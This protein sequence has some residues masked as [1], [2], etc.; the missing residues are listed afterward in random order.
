MASHHGVHF[1][2]GRRDYDT[3]LGAYSAALDEI[4]QLRKAMAYEAA[5][6]EAHLSLKSFPKS[7]RQYAEKQ[8]E[9]MR[10]AA[11]GEVETAYAGC[12][13]LSMRHAMGEA[14]ADQTMT[15]LQWEAEKGFRG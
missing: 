4:W 9:Q 6:I 5:T 1:V 10:A 3:L 2:D 8:V 11:R 13:S 15:R 14:G 7:R 12:S